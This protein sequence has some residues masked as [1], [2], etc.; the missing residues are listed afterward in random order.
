MKQFAWFY[1]FN[2]EHTRVEEAVPS[3]VEYW[4]PF[5]SE[6]YLG[7]PFGD[8]S[9]GLIIFEAPSIEEATEISMKDPF[10]VDGLLGEK[11]IKEW[12]PM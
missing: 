2:V 4:K 5:K 6:R 12:I 1:L 11:W 8:R 9:G 3:H 10:R 7:G